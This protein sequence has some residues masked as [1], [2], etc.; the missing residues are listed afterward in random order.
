LQLKS[1]VIWL[2]S[3]EH[4]SLAGVCFCKLQRNFSFTRFP[5]TIFC[6]LAALLL[7]SSLESF[8]FNCNYHRGSVWEEHFLYV[9]DA[10]VQ[11]EGN[12]MSVQAVN[13][14]HLPGMNNSLVTGL[15]LLTQRAGTRGYFPRNIEHFFPNLLAI[16]IDR[17]VDELRQDS[18]Q[19]FSRLRTLQFTENNINNRELRRVNLNRNRVLQHAANHIFD[20]LDLINIYLQDCGC[21]NTFGTTPAGVVNT[22]RILTRDCP[23]TTRMI[24]EEIMDEGGI[25]IDQNNLSKKINKVQIQVD[26]LA[27]QSKIMFDNLNFIMS[28]LFPQ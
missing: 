13:G 19:P 22:I 7:I 2:Q 27:V 15:R 10:I 9:C 12:T 25:T 11:S 17:S 3:G 6:L 26:D 18:L 21:I 8:T 24:V 4:V 1:L 16:A 20:G 23:A 5:K 14:N 28:R